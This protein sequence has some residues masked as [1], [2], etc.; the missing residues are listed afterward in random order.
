[1]AGSGSQGMVKIT[2]EETARKLSQN[3]DQYVVQEY[4]PGTVYSI[5]V[6]G[7]PGNHAVFQVTELGMD[8]IHDCKRVVAPTLLPEKLKKDLA[9]SALAC[10]DALNLW[11]L[12]DVE[13]V[14]H[15]GRMKILE[16]DARLPSQTPTAVFHSTRINLLYALAQPFAPE[17]SPQTGGGPVGGVV[18]EHVRVSENTVAVSGEHVMGDA[19]PLFFANRFFRGRRG[20]GPGPCPGPAL[21]R[22]LDHLR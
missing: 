20:P 4:L 9:A 19:G 10:A 13:A 3:P 8:Q 2:D 22:H 11:G 12:M 21:L 14:A 7:S 15:D 6:A 5:E 17:L 1:M 18:Y 16:I